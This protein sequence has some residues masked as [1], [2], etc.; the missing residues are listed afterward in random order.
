MR[1]LVS[2]WLIKLLMASSSLWSLKSRASSM[3]NGDLIFSVG[4]DIGCLLVFIIVT[5]S[6]VGGYKARFL[7]FAPLAMVILP[8]QQPI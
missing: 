8:C 5:L 3:V 4:Y 6:Y 7:I 1:D 2:V